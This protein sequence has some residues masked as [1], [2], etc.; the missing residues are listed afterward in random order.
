MATTTNQGVSDV[1]GNQPYSAPAAAQK[2][3]NYGKT[4]GQPQLSE[5]AA[6]YYEQLKKKF[7]N[8]DFVLVSKDQK[9]FAKN[10]AASF[11][12]S[13]KT[14]VLIDEE[15]IE[16]MARDE[17][18]R[19]QYEG[20]I[21]NAA[22]G[23]SQLKAQMEKSGANVKGYGAQI[24]DGGVTTFFAVLKKSNAEQKDR[25]EKKAQE[26][27]AERRA[28]KKRAAKKEAEERIHG[29]EGSREAEDEDTVTLTASSIEELMQKINDYTMAERSDMVMTEEEQQVGGHIDFKG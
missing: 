17:S 1:Y 7:G 14:V 20:I 6:Q 5:E 21:S 15:K 2:T 16:R 25:I 12:N 11:A 9:E 28:E 18:F 8:M 13:F 10:N 4:V 26:T 24:N 19:K 29:K 22:S 27:R 23:I 3:Q